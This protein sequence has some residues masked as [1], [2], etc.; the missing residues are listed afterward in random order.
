MNRK[1]SKKKSIHEELDVASRRGESK[2]DSNRMNQHLHFD[3]E[4]DLD[5]YIPVWLVRTQLNLRNTIKP[6][7]RP[8]ARAISKIT[9]SEFRLL[10]NVALKGPLSP[11]EIAKVIG[12][13]RAT[14]TRTLATLVKKGLVSTHRDKTD[15][16]SK[17]LLLTEKGRSM[18]DELIPP[19]KAFGIYLDS[20]LTEYE[21]R[22]LRRILN[23]LVAASRTYSSE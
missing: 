8:P 3:E 16:R 5:E 9:K 11:S 13:D 10:V 2:V 18:C 15:Q 4:F 12:L 17:S 23:K 1:T 6:E 7:G 20:A 14:V 22:S 21:K 19:M